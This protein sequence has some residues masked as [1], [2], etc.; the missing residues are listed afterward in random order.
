MRQRISQAR[1]L[2]FAGVFAAAPLLASDRLERRFDLQPGGKLR[3][4]TSVGQVRVTG[5][6]GS[7]AHLLVNAHGHDLDEILT[8][9]F[10]ES[11]TSVTISARSKHHFFSFR[12]GSVE[13]DL[14]V[15]SETSV[16]IETSGGPIEASGLR[17][18]AK[19]DTSGGSIS[20]HDL[21]ANLQAHSSGGPIHLRD[22][23]GDSRVNTSGGGIDASHL[24][25]KL[26]AETSGGPI[27]L[28]EITG[29]ADVHS[30]GGGIRIRNAGGRVVAETSGGSIDAAF[31][32]GN[33]RGGSLESSGGG[34][35]VAL[36]PEVGLSIDAEADHVQSDLPLRVQGEISRRSL[37]GSLGNGGEKLLLRT[38]GGGIR[39]QSL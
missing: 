39:I 29:D 14:E 19:L 12:S 20:V 7:G 28:D 23:R 27:S 36:D 25:G 6:P 2:T 38:S 16:D 31:A 9:R 5:K 13:F 10:D 37:R 34:I 33:G 8:F 3:L 4:E 22:I 17:A 18:P 32:K 35:T 11:P 30:S 1:L 26:N 21:N 24:Q 15:P